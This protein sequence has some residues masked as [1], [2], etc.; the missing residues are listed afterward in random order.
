M[1]L[2]SE[3]N[4]SVGEMHVLPI[5]EAEN[6]SPLADSAASVQRRID[7][8][9]LATFASLGSD[10]APRTVQR[11]WTRIRIRWRRE[12]RLQPLGRGS[13]GLSHSVWVFA[14]RRRW[15]LSCR[16]FPGERT[17]LSDVSRCGNKP[18]RASTGDECRHVSHTNEAIS[19][20]RWSRREYRVFSSDRF[21]GRPSI[22]TSTKK[23][24]RRL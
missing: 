7:K 3:H 2:T 14:I 17:P 12:S 21:L 22:T 16:A 23:R 10:D 15:R 18:H 13:R 6:G 24:P 20:G 1:V 11:T 5:R 4:H 9:R 19:T 8:I